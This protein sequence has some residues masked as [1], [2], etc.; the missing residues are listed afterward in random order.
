MEEKNRREEV[1]TDGGGGERGYVT[2]T[3]VIDILSIKIWWCWPA[4]LNTLIRHYP[5]EEL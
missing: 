3:F 1:Q 2:L 5:R 4:I